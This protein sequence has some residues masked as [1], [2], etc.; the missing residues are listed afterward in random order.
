MKRLWSLLGSLL[1]LNSAVGC[2]TMGPLA[3]GGNDPLAM[4]LAGGGCCLTK[5]FKNKK[6]KHGCGCQPGF[7]YDVF[8][9]YDGGCGDLGCGDLGYGGGMLADGGFHYGAPGASSCGCG[10]SHAAPAPQ[11]A[12]AQQYA[13]APTAIPAVPAAPAFDPAPA[14]PPAAPG[15]GIEPVPMPENPNLNGQQT[16]FGAPAQNVSM[17]EFQRLPGTIISGP[18]AAP[19]ATAP[20][21]QLAVPAAPAR[22]AIPT[23][24]QPGVRPVNWQPTRGR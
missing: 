21:P 23:A 22:T 6:N 7:G 17:E 9:S 19:A 3:V 4:E 24:A 8:P 10:Q 2:C 13:P 14:A 18:G 5:H 1:V 16:Q 20:A 11:F 12:P 15:P